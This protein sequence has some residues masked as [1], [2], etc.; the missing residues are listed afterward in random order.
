MKRF[1][2]LLTL[3]FSV[4]CFSTSA[5]SKSLL[6]ED[7][8]PWDGSGQSNA[9]TL[10]TLGYSYDKISSTTFAGL[11][12]ISNYD[13]VVFASDQYQAYYNNI[14]SNSSL[15]NSYVS[16]GGTLIA[17]ATIWGWHGGT[18]DYA[19]GT[20]FLPGGVT[21]VNQYSN[22]VKILDPSSGVIDGD[23][24][25]V[26]EADLQSWGWSTH[27][28]FTNLLAGTDVI[29]GI[30]DDSKPCYIE[31]QYGLGTVRANMMTLEW[32]QGNAAGTRQIFRNNEFALV[33]HET[34]GVPEP[35]TMLLLGL[36]LIGLAGVRKKIKK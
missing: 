3:V 10:S 33:E 25:T 21:A 26:S 13:Y 12:N 2:V 6:I 8:T 34:N 5:F 20:G 1:I 16:N 32:G 24:G 30:G 27:G 36:G 7:V 22:S 31:Y 23:F 18:W 4:A 28:Y 14:A 19:G 35:A 11:S 15:I 29:I 9:V 17:H